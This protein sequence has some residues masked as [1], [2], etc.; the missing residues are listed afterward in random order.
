M[1]HAVTILSLALLTACAKDKPTA[2]SVPAP[3]A[4]DATIAPAQYAPNGVI[5]RTAITFRWGKVPNAVGY[6]IEHQRSVNNNSPGPYQ[7]WST[8]MATD[9][10]A[11]VQLPAGVLNYGRWRAIARGPNNVTGGSSGWM[12]FEIQ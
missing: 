8:T 7:A 10:T 12:Y 2:P 5:P 1:K 6:T 3:P 4:F 9:T 11:V